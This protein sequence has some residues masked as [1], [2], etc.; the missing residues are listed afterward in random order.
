MRAGAYLRA[1]RQW[2]QAAGSTAQ[3]R[4]R[5]SA[6]CP[7]SPPLPCETLAMGWGREGRGRFPEPR[8]EQ[9][10]GWGQEGC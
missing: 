5:S 4:S 2:L 9:H 8:V 6:A 10:L 3:R 7:T 1:G